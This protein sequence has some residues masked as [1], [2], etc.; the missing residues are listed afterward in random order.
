MAATVAFLYQRVTHHH[1]HSRDPDQERDSQANS[2]RPRAQKNDLVAHQKEKGRMAQLVWLL[3]SCCYSLC[4][5]ANLFQQLCPTVLR[6]I[7]E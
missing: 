7:K 1:C 5:F 4:E 2:E 3:C 6:P